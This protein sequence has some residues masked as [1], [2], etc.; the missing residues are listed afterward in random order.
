MN[1]LSYTR[2]IVWQHAGLCKAVAQGQASLWLNLISH[3]STTNLVLFRVAQRES[4]VL[5]VLVHPKSSIETW[6][7]GKLGILMLKACMELS[8]EYRG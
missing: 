7:A 3:I 4:L 1:M 5:H 2:P 8:D 6:L